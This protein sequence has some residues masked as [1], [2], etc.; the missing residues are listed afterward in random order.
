MNAIVGMCGRWSVLYLLSGLAFAAMAQAPGLGT[1]WDARDVA[2]TAAAGAEPVRIGIWDSGVDLA[3]FPAQLARDADGQPL[4]RGYDASKLRHG[5]RRWRCF[6][7]PCWR[8]R[9]N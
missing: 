5:T 6:R 7:R 1:F 3:L 8:G 4:V 9:T 2:V